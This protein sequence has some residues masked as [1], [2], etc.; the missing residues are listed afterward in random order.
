M[1]QHKP[2]TIIYEDVKYSFPTWIKALRF[3]HEKIQPIPTRKQRI[4]L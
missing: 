3:I 2:V 4:Y 1:T